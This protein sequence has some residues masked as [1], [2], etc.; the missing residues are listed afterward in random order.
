MNKLA[1]IRQSVPQKAAFEYLALLHLRTVF[2]S[3]RHRSLGNGSPVLPPC[4]SCSDALAP[5]RTFQ[6]ERRSCIPVKARFHTRLCLDNC[7]WIKIL[8]TICLWPGCAEA[9]GQR[10]PGD[11]GVGG[12]HVPFL[13]GSLRTARWPSWLL[14]FPL[15]SLS[16]SYSQGKNIWLLFDL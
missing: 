7:L 13:A 8:D 1:R 2:V 6:T 5:S 9:R 14:P 12:Y 16:A 3:A 15:L 11:R 10:S 4:S